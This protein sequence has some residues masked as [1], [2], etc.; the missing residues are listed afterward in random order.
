MQA[1]LALSYLADEAGSRPVRAREVAEHLSIPV[2]SALKILQT[3]CRAG[4][5]RSRLGRSGGYVLDR[6]ASQVTLLEVF[7]VIDGALSATT[8]L[9]RQEG[10]LEHSVKLMENVASDAAFY[11]RERL[12]K[13]TIGSLQ[14]AEP[15]SDRAE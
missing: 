7:E 10:A 14:Q 13:V 3:L 2:D 8:G 11:L 9:S 4:L 1:A 15:A 6:D 5:I 12:A